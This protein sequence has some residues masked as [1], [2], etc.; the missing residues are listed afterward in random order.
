MIPLDSNETNLVWLR[1]GHFQ[2]SFDLAAGNGLIATLAFDEWIGPA[3]TAST[4][5]GTFTFRRRSRVDPVIE[6]R[7]EG[8]RVLLV[9]GASPSEG[10]IR[11]YE[12][13]CPNRWHRDFL[14]TT[15]GG[16]ELFV[17]YHDDSRASRISI[18]N[19]DAGA[20]DLPVLVLTAAYLVEA[21]IT[22][23]DRSPTISNGDD[24]NDPSGKPG[25]AGARHRLP[26][27]PAT[28]GSRE[29][30]HEDLAHCRRPGGTGCHG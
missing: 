10:V 1:R 21:G 17:L 25:T 6:V 15:E 29:G 2:R 12:M 13:R 24:G 14:I 11:R 4:A 5:G 28:T 20:A 18:S 7:D 3:A 9:V 19:R 26:L 8:D 22:R 16:R 30:Q 27:S 23:E